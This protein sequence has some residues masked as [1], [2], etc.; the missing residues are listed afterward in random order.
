MLVWINYGLAMHGKSGPVFIDLAWFGASLIN[1]EISCDYHHLS[2]KGTT[3]NSSTRNE[4]P[5]DCWSFVLL[6]DSNVRLYRSGLPQFREYSY[7]RLS[8]IV[9]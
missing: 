1:M 9:I 7:F 2:T 8:T 3:S 5:Y 4:H 6:G